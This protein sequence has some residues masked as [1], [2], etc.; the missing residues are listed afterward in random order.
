MSSVWAGACAA[1]ALTL[2]AAGYSE[3]VDRADAT[4]AQLDSSSATTDAWLAPLGVPGGSATIGAVLAD[5]PADQ[6]I[7]FIGPADQPALTLFFY[8]VSVIA[9]P[10][11]VG[12]IRCDPGGG[13]ADVVISP[14]TPSLGAALVHQRCTE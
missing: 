10:N 7:F 1:A 8:N 3:V 6:G 2:F 5:V 11:K 14:P 9:F 12:L 13:P 4:T